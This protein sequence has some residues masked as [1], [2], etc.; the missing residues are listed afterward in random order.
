[1]FISDNKIL[2]KKLTCRNL[3][4]K[5]TYFSWFKDPKKQK[6]PN[7]FLNP[8]ENKCIS[9]IK[10]WWKYK[11][12]DLNY[13]DIKVIWELSRFDWVVILAQHHVLG[14]LSALVDLNSTLKNWM[15]K[16]PPYFGPNWMCAQEAAIRVIHLLIAEKI[17][18]EDPRSNQ[19]LESVIE[20]HIL[21]I[22]YTTLYSKAQKNNHI[23]SEGV[24]LYIG[25]LWLRSK[26]YD[27]K[28][29]IKKGSK[30][31]EKQVDYLIDESGMFSQ[32][33]SNYHRMLVDLLSISEIFREKYRVQKFS[34]KFYFKAELATNWLYKIVSLETGEV[35]NLGSN[36]GTNLL[37]LT[38]SKYSDF[39]PSLLLASH[40][41]AYYLNVPIKKNYQDILDWL[42]VKTN[43]CT[44]SK[45]L[46]EFNSG[47]VA[48]IKNQNWKIFYRYPQ[49]NFRP[50]DCD[51][52]HLDIWHDEE[53]VICDSG[54]YSYADNEF[55]DIYFSGS[56]GHNN[57]EFDERDSMPKYS[58]FLRTNWL[59]YDFFYFDESSIE[60]AYTDSFGVNHHRRVSFQDKNILV[61]D[62]FKGYKNKAILRWH[63]KNNGSKLV[64]GKNKQVLR[65]GKLNIYF[66]S[67]RPISHVRLVDGWSAKKYFKK[68]KIEILEIEFD[69]HKSVQV[70]TNITV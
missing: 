34:E 56:K 25:G 50:G 53:N 18:S 64:F 60:S 17:I 51:Q 30:I 19:Y 52:M 21:R 14:N 13:G 38:N 49:Y 69:L 27:S 29:Y 36:D 26:G 22:Y 62:N 6:L 48:C 54:T 35:P 23:I 24:G 70:R 15:E 1:M 41:F 28:R 58:K 3:S 40:L 20:T 55:Q 46:Y 42:N 63:F 67:N 32:Y 61:E 7:W 31:L 47:G 4:S 12:V 44:K 33:S 8:I 16:N 66:S 65:F 9:E 5:F 59:S 11:S 68:N 37:P 39:R 57:I 45:Y 43:L 10:P 2:D